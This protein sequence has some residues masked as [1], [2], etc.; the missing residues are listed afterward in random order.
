MSACVPCGSLLILVIKG[1]RFYQP[2]GQGFES[3]HLTACGILA[4]WPGLN[5]CLLPWKHGV[6][7]PGPPGRSSH[8]CFETYKVLSPGSLPTWLGVGSLP[9]FCLVFFT[10]SLVHFVFVFC[11]SSL[12]MY[13]S[14]DFTSLFMS[15][16]PRI[17]SSIWLVLSEL[18]MNEQRSREWDV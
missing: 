8:S 4:T 10:H 12:E 1:H 11:L 2:Q 6:F 18:L 15:L 14:R 7:S 5:M 16:L 3:L 9:S 13:V 17:V